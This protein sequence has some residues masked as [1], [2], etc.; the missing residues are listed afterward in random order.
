M[1]KISGFINLNK[2]SGISSAAAVSKIKKLTGVP[3]G[4][5]GTLDPL[6]SGVL[7]VA[8]G[9]AARLFQYLLDKQKTYRAVF[10]FGI[11]T[12]TLDCTGEVYCENMPVPDE[13]SI[14]SVLAR[15]TGEIMQMPP[16]FSAKSIGGVRAYKLA[17]EGKE[18]ALQPKA[19]RIDGLELIGKTGADSYEF[20]IRCGG[21]TYVRSI[22]RDVV[23]C[24]GTCA[25][26]TSLVR[27]KSGYFSL[28]NSVSLEDL[29]CRGGKDCLIAPDTV[30][31]MPA[32][33]YSGDLAKRIGYGQTIA[34]DEDDGLYK[35]YLDGSFYG[36]AA[37]NGG[38][39]KAKTKV[40]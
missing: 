34:A 24:L 23:E 15:F 28:E 27:E 16:A 10:R 5:M 6:A 30:F 3:C 22:G 9:N 33:C 14:R 18:V 17:R 20:L 29:A 39:L 21:G 7:P 1:D 40:C 32:L 31:E 35:L 13:E 2:P 38:L 26:M 37:V 8:V 4:H 19:V 12:D 36:V 11:G 25:V